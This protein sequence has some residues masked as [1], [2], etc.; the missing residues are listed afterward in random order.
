MKRVFSAMISALLV[1][2]LLFI[3]ACNE[4]IVDSDDYPTA[5]IHE[6]ESDG[7]TAD[8]E[9][10]EDANNDNREE[11]D[12][13]SID[14]ILLHEIDSLRENGKFVYNPVTIH[15]A[16]L[17][18]TQDN[19][20][21]VKAAKKIMQTVY[22]TGS[23]VEFEEGEHYTLNELQLAYS[24]AM[25]STPLMETVGLNFEDTDNVTIVY[26]PQY[27]TDES[28]NPE[29]SEDA[30][31]GEAREKYEKFEQYITDTI[32]ENITP[33]NSD[34]ERAAIIF[35]EIVKDFEY[36]SDA[37]TG[38][39]VIEG[40]GELQI[41]HHIPDSLVDCVNSG[42]INE[43]GMAEL[44]RF[45]MTQLNIKCINIGAEGQY[46]SQNIERT[47]KE[48]EDTK[49]WEWNLIYLGEDSYHCDLYFEKA[50]Y[51][52]N[53]AKYEDYEPE[54]EYFGMSDNTRNKSFTMYNRFSIRPMY[55]TKD[56]G[57]P[58]CES[59]YDAK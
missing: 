54:L 17:M 53:K 13:N 59:D 3:S 31:R 15:P 25:I 55:F 56:I 35:G 37:E 5:A 46:K 33:E 20:K 50:L 21:A 39:D 19:P 4:K 8:G 6:S 7:K 24:L 16:Y 30:G 57:I 11:S 42:K 51:D 52:E 22:E 28:G 47:D 27:S 26:F 49:M 41:E 18:L 23:E 38:Y 48:F 44:Y 45:F 40:S 43:S 36:V 10:N 9:K 32:N 58:S 12:G 29:V 34:E 1:L 2:S 14:E